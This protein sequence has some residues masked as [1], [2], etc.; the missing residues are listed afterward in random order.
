[1]PMTA[2]L[3]S[4]I[5]IAAA[6]P[7][8]GCIALAAIPVV[9]AGGF[10]GERALNPRPHRNGS[11]AVEAGLVTPVAPAP[12]VAAPALT[13]Q[14]EGGPIALA[15]GA[16][17]I[18]PSQAIPDGASPYAR[19][20]DFALSREA[21]RIG[22]R[23]LPSMVLAAGT[24]ILSPDYVACG[25]KPPAVVIDFDESGGRSGDA[26]ELSAQRRHVATLAADLARLRAA[27]FTVVWLSDVPFD[28]DQLVYARLLSLGLD[29]AGHDP[30]YSRL[31]PGDGRAGRQQE[32]AARFCVHAMAGDRKAA[33]FDGYDF[34]NAPE[35]AG[36]IDPNWDAGWFLLP[37]PSQL[38]NGAATVSASPTLPTP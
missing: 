37:S 12:A 10:V 8:S 19:L 38:A 21:A 35:L 36:S 34:L 25:D 6:V 4:L 16:A 17:G 7:L 33:I 15:P 2:A 13:P 1:M 14:T 20:V 9:A 30:L 28:Q 31:L 18:D 24:N 11:S 3:R 23:Q 29:P 26:G 5:L 32:I 22:G 27:H